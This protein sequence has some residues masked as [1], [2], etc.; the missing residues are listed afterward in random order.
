[1]PAAIGA[2]RIAQLASIEHADEKQLPEARYRMLHRQ[3]LECSVDPQQDQAVQ[4]EVEEL[5][6]LASDLAHS[7]AAKRSELVEVD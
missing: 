6:H 7:M 2:I 5:A 4:E 1:M 3:P